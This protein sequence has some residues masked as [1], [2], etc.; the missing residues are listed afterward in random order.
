MKSERE[1]I[2][3]EEVVRIT[4]TEEINLRPVL[5]EMDNRPSWWVTCASYLKAFQLHPF[6]VGSSSM[7]QDKH[8]LS[9]VRK[10]YFASDEVDRAV[11]EGTFSGSKRELIQRRNQLICKLAVRAGLCS[12]AVIPPL[13]TENK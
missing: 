1:V 10:L 6:E 7:P 11:M 3:I 12:Y 8:I 9:A 2:Q 5:L 4:E 13:E